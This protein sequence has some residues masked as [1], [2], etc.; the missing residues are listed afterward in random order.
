MTVECTMKPF[1]SF[2]LYVYPIEKSGELLPVSDSPFS[3]GGSPNSVA[4]VPSGR[5]RLRR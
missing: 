2:N 5:F 3:A 1:G 4:V